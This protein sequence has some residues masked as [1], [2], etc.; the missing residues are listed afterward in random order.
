[1]FSEYVVSLMQVGLLDV[2]VNNL[3]KVLFLATM[4]LS[5]VLISV[6]VSVAYVQYT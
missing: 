4:T 6:K 5:L 1:M 2:E 3:T